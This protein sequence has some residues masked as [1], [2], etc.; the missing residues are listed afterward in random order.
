[1]IDAMFKHSLCNKGNQLHLQVNI[2]PPVD[3]LM[4]NIT[5]DSETQTVLNN[6]FDCARHFRNQ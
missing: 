1:M 6:P 5:H 4:I 2:V 3:I